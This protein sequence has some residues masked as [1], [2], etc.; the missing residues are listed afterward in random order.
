M[1]FFLEDVNNIVAH[2]AETMGNNDSMFVVA[3]VTIG[4]ATD[5]DGVDAGSGCSFQVMGTIMS[6]GGNGLYLSGSGN[7][8]TVA[9]GGAI[10]GNLNAGAALTAAAGH[11]NL[12]NAGIISGSTGIECGSSDNIITNTGTIAGNGGHAIH[13]AWSVQNFIFNSGTISS[14]G[15]SA[16]SIELERQLILADRKFWNDRVLVQRGNLRIDRLGRR[17]QQW[18][19]FRQRSAFRRRLPISGGHG[20]PSGER[21]SAARAMTRS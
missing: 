11:I 21:C 5:W 19:Y 10:L 2:N 9:Q 3:G 4:S 20:Y 17:D 12:T 15:N 13:I 1:A 6:L 8:I 7:S 16:I 14:M 18:A